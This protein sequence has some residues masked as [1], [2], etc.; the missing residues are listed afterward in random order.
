MLTLNWYCYVYC[1][2]K[3]RRFY[4]YVILVSDP[5]CFEETKYVQTKTETHKEPHDQNH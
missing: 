2:V 1:I 4:K 5:F 3:W